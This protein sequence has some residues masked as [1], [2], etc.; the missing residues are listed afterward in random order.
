MVVIFRGVV[1][2]GKSMRLFLRCSNVSGEGW[3]IRCVYCVNMY[4]LANLERRVREGR[5]IL[6]ERI[7]VFLEGLVET[8]SRGG[9]FWE[10]IRRFGLNFEEE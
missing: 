8:E 6:G 1:T 4:F 10:G 9:F 5:G 3:V 7:L 2:I